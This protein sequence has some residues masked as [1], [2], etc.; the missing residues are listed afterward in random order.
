MDPIKGVGGID[1]TI[2]VS[3][4]KSDAVALANTLPPLTHPKEITSSIQESKNM[5]W[6]KTALRVINFL[7]SLALGALILGSALATNL[8]I[9]TIACSP[10]GW[11]IAG[12]VLL[13]CLIG[14][15][16]YGGIEE[17]KN[18]ALLSLGGLTAGAA[19]VVSEIAAVAAVTY[20]VE[21]FAAVCIARIANPIA[22]ESRN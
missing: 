20:C 16:Y 12:G 17:F 7:A 14:S 6:I 1:R 22:T 19:I 18:A 10:I 13:I 5:D 4:S 2:A 15:A 8:L 21:A 9:S 3:V 11:A